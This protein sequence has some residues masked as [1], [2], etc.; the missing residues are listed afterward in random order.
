M[1]VG[2]VSFLAWVFLLLDGG[3]CVMSDDAPW[4]FGMRLIA[5]I[6]LSSKMLFLTTGGASPNIGVAVGVRR[7]RGK[8]TASN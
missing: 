7:C 3:P 5:F 6:N 2:L 1:Y 8:T 4:Y